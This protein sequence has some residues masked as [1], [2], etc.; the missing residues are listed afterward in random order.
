MPK[1]CVLADCDDTHTI[2]VHLNPTAETDSNCFYN[3][4]NYNDKYSGKE[5]LIWARHEKLGVHSPR[6]HC[7]GRSEVFGCLGQHIS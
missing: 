5:V 4:M 1:L 3:G 7:D 2:T 6:E